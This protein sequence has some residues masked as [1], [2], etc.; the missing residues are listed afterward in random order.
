MTCQEL[1]LYFEDP[2]RRDAELRPELE[3]LTHCPDCA[4]FVEAQRELGHSLRVT[5]E[6]AP[7]FPASLDTVVLANYRQHITEQSK[8]VVAICGKHGFAIL[9]WSVAAAALALVAA[10][11]YFAEGTSTRTLAQPQLIRPV[12]P[13]PSLSPVATASQSSR[14][15][16][17]R[18]VVP[19]T[20][21]RPSAP[22]EATLTS[23]L[24]SGFRS[25]MYCDELSCGDVMEVIRVQLPPS[26]FLITGMGGSRP[27]SADVLVGS[28]GIARGIRVVE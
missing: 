16:S 9:G 15:K 22:T 24:P 14:P 5:R 2:L 1:R 4:R 3:H 23:P 12:A 20:Q 11:L 27:I 25:L 19:K 18:M 10:L 6:S 26:P 28:D 21:P 8:P 17:P 13:A 7:A